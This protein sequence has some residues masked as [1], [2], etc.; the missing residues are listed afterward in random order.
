[1]S[2]IG[3]TVALRGLIDGGSPSELYLKQYIYNYNSVITEL[4]FQFSAIEREAQNPANLV[5]LPSGLVIN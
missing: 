1:M 5:A 3:R 2:P 4:F